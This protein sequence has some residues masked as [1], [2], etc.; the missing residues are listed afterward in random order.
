MQQ[1]KYRFEIKYRIS[2]DLA[3]EM[4]EWIKALG[5]L[6]AD[7][8]GEGGS[9]AYNVH[10]LYLDNRD[11]AIYAETRAGLQQRYKV[12]ARCYE[13]SAN[14]KVFLEVKHRANEYMW[15]TR[16]EVTKADGVRILSGL[17]PLEAKSTDALE[18]FRGLMD[19]RHLYPRVW[20]TYR[21][22]AYVGGVRDLVRVTFDTKI[23]AAPPTMDLNEPPK[24]YVVPESDGIEI[25][26]LKYTGS[27]PSWVGDMVRRFNL[28]RKAFSKFRYGIDALLDAEGPMRRDYADRPE[29]FVGAAE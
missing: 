22:H 29:F 8:F 10:S 6:K 24:W 1:R 26:E 7:D 17:V 20:V 12:R 13:W 28:E 23:K 9:A 14:A 21:R 25:L 4:R 3:L 18:N 19:R 2:P 11:W 16:G 15:K 27:Y 5:H